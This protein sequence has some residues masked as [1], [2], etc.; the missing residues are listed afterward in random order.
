MSAREDH[1]VASRFTV[2]NERDRPT[3][4]VSMNGTDGNGT[5]RRSSPDE[6]A[7]AQSVMPP[8]PQEK[9]SMTTSTSPTHS[10]EWISLYSP[11]GSERRHTSTQA[12]P[13]LRKRAFSHRTKTGCV[14][15][16][17]RKKKCDEARPQCKRP[18][19]R[20]LPDYLELMLSNRQQLSP[21]W[22]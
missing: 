8:P 3:I 10:E 9:P 2:I 20:T 16:R 12:D 21:C 19:P 18:H 11:Y 5:P 1:G 17:R 7:K 15:C 4:M 6:R 22:L 13:K 14:T